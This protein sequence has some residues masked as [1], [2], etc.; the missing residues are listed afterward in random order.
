L[1]QEKRNLL[2]VYSEQ[3]VIT[4]QLVNKQS[5]ATFTTNFVA[6]SV[7]ILFT[8][9]SDRIGR[10]DKYKLESMSEFMWVY[11]FAMY[12]TTLVHIFSVI[13]LFKRSPGMYFTNLCFGLKVFGKNQCQ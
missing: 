4:C 6:I 9:T 10:L 12:N 11:V 13:V 5:L 1:V 7:I 2:P 3:V 8:T